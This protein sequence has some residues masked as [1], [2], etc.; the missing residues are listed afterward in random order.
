MDVEGMDEVLA[1]YRDLFDLAEKKPAAVRP[2]RGLT[3]EEAQMRLAEGFALVDLKDLLPE[4]SALAS[5]VEDVV[6]ILSRYSEDTDAL[7]KDMA[8]LVEDQTRLADLARIYLG[9]GEEALRNKLLSIEGVNPEV[10]MFILFNAL[11]GA[12]L[13]AAAAHKALDTS[14]WDEGYC[15]VCGG[16]ASVSYMIG[17]GGKRHL[18]C[19]RCEAH[20]RFRRLVCPYC[21]KEDPEHSGLLYS[22]DTRYRNLSANVCTECR[23]YIKGWRVEGDELDDLNPQIEDLKTPGFDRAVEEEGFSRGAPNI[24][25]VWIGALTEEGEITD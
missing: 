24:Y 18:I 11:K 16:D 8:G 20:W 10:V 2:K 9:E 13:Q 5:D 1:L 19:F 22:D 4:P 6:Q 7:E 23:S 12:F 17:E 25:G 3:V 15:P 21:G 14:S